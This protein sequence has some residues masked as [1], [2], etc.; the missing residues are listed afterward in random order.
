MATTPAATSASATSRSGAHK[1]A[2]PRI[3]GQADRYLRELAG[4]AGT[5]SRFPNPTDDW[6]LEE[7]DKLAQ[8]RTTFEA[9][10]WV[11]GRAFEGPINEIA[12]GGRAV[13]VH[14]VGAGH[15][16]ND[17]F[18]VVEDVNVVHCGDL[19]FN[20]M[21][22][23][24]DPNGGGSSKGWI[25]SLEGI[26]KVCDAETKVVPGHGELTNIDGVKKGKAYQE[27]LRDAVTAE[28]KKGT[29]KEK[30]VEMSW[31]FMD[32]LGRQQLR[33]RAVSFVYDE[34]RSES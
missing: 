34:V 21:H 24:F 12:F 3:A 27:Q 11:P 1:N 20:D 14:H 4:G 7:A 30:V 31:D 13:K 25:E 17:A 8:R 18:A 29:P 16:D 15:T 23:Y 10:D 32:G 19:L 2:I 6:M 22:P 33:P 5:F 28:V 26:I 9:E